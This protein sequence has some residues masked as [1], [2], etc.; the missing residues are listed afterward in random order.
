MA[1]EYVAP[2][3]AIT[4]WDTDTNGGT[5]RN[6]S[7]LGDATALRRTSPDDLLFGTTAR[8]A[9]DSIS[10]GCSTKKSRRVGRRTLA[11]P[12]AV[13]WCRFLRLCPRPNRY[14]RTGATITSATRSPSATS[15]SPRRAVAVPARGAWSRSGCTRPALS[16]HNHLE[17]RRRNSRQPG[18]LVVVPAWIGRAAHVPAGA[19]VGKQHPVA[20][21]RAEDHADG[22]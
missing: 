3:L 2:S 22:R 18:Q 17:R 8:D 11:P 16:R 6:G 21:H 10:S 13:R 12:E 5:D 19:V 20:H 7:L 15:A 4:T 14:G 1:L 9:T